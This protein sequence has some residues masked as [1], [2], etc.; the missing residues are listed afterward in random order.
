MKVGFIG[1]GRMGFRIAKNIS[2]KYNTN[3]WNRTNEISLKHSL[4]YN[5]RNFNNIDKLIKKSNI[6]FTCLPTS[7]KFLVL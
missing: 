7:K 5:T 4:E 1:L 3:V 2:K 6:L